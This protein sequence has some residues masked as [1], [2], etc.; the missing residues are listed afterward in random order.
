[1]TLADCLPNPHK[2]ISKPAGQLFDAKNREEAYQFEPRAFGIFSLSRSRKTIVRLRFP[3]AVEVVRGT[4]L[5]VEVTVVRPENCSPRKSLPF[6]TP[7]LYRDPVVLR[8]LKWQTL[9]S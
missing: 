5:D 6:R 8:P 1:M 9:A 2:Q 7:D 3:H 4:T